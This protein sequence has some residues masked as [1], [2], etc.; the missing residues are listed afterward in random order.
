MSTRA[1]Q[2]VKG[3]TFKEGA[4]FTR[5]NNWARDQR[6]AGTLDP[7][8]DIRATKFMNWADPHHRVK[9]R[10]NA[11]IPMMQFGRNVGRKGSVAPSMS[12]ADKI[13]TYAPRSGDNEKDRRAQATIAAPA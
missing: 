7:S 1:R 12:S 3:Q 6:K 4:D 13:V 9:V 2:R 10:A 8:P 11:D 5:W